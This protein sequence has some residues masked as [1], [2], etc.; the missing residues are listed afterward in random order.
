MT[1]VSEDVIHELRC[2]ASVGAGVPDLLRLLVNRLGPESAYGTTLAR[3]FM[4]AF[5]LSL[6]QVAAIGGWS[7]NS[8]GDISDARIQDMIYPEMLQQKRRWERFMTPPNRAE[9][10][11]GTL[12]NLDETIA[13]K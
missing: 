3:Y 13:R 1:E 12:V 9:T 10:D 8:A 4:A 11:T 6:H 2:A 5:H 7:P